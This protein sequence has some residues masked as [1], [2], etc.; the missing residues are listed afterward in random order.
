MSLR[1]LLLP[2]LPCGSSPSL[3]GLLLNSST[4]LFRNWG[5]PAISVTAT[6]TDSTTEGQIWELKR[7]WEATKV[8]YFGESVEGRRK[9]GDRRR[10]GKVVED[11]SVAERRVAHGG[12]DGGI[13]VGIF[14]VWILGLILVLFVFGRRITLNKRQAHCVCICVFDLTLL[15]YSLL[16]IHPPP[17]FSLSHLF[18][19]KY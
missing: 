6:T 17:W 2:C 1:R 12:G 5:G 19:F 9:T 18:K 15:C 8:S 7:A 14:K 10:V 3:E 16:S 13:V 11:G 4:L